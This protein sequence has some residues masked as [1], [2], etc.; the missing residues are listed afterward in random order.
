MVL[1][2]GGEDFFFIAQIPIVKLGCNFTTFVGSFSGKGKI[3]VLV[4][5]GDQ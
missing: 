2:L 1:W 3:A 4:K 5:L